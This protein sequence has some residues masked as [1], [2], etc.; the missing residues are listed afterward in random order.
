MSELKETPYRGELSAR[1]IVKESYYARTPQQPGPVNLKRELAQLPVSA[2]YLLSG[3]GRH[4]ADA[5]FSA[6]AE[7]ARRGMSG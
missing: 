4:R 2:Q 7:A 6:F 5:A 1:G 3:L